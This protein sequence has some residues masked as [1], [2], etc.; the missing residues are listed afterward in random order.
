VRR[1]DILAIESCKHPPQSFLLEHPRG[2]TSPTGERPIIATAFVHHNHEVLERVREMTNTV[3]RRLGFD[4]RGARFLGWSLQ[5]QRLGFYFAGQRAI[6]F[7]LSE[8]VIIPID[9]C[10]QD[11]HRIERSVTAEPS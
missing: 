11:L 8:L 5:Q 6:A 4:L 7:G 10:E 3:L 9:C 1:S 2:L